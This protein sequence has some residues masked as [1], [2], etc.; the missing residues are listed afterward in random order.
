MGAF[1]ILISGANG[2][3]KMIN[4]FSNNEEGN[5]PLAYIATKVRSATNRDCVYFNHI[6]GVDCLLI[7]EEINVFIKIKFVIKQNI[8]FLVNIKPIS[9]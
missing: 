4:S 7:E 9:K 1:F 8:Y 5:Y 3:S 2:Y 6:D